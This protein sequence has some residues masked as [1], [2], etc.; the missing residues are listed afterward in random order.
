MTHRIH[1]RSL[2]IGDNRTSVSLEDA[3]WDEFRR[4]CAARRKT[5]GEVCAEIKATRPHNLS[6]A[7]RLFVLEEVSS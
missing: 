1:K 4:I 3:F 2:I 7:I 6:S 5:P